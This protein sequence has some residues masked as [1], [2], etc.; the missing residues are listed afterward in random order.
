M[1]KVSLPPPRLTPPVIWKVSLPSEP[2][3]PIWKVSLP[4]LPV[5]PPL[6]SASPI[7]RECLHTKPQ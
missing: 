2:A 3:L 5:T 7:L 4:A 6:C 1:I